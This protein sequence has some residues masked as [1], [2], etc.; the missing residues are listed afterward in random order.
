MLMQAQ[1]VEELMKILEGLKPGWF[2]TTYS[3]IEMTLRVWDEKGNSQGS[4]TLDKLI[5]VKEGR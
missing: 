2:I 3:P 4:I 5:E 1:T